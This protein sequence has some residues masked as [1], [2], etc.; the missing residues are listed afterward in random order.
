MEKI[1]DFYFVFHEVVCC[2]TCILESHR[3]C[4]QIA[5]IN[6]ACDGIKSSALVEDVSKAL[7]SLLRT[8]DS[9]IENRKYN[10]ES[11]Y[12]QE[13]TIKESI[14]KLKQCLLQHV[15]SLEK[16]L[17]SDLAKLQ[18]ET[19]SQLDAE[20][21]ESKSLSENWQKTKLEYD[22]NIKHGSNSQFFRL[23]EN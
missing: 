5:L 9:V 1:V 7:S 19:V 2:Q 11:I 6:D 4:E 12:L 3:A 14:V 17:L 16:S 10:K 18:D 22:F 21:S 23:V 8:F 15:D 20:I 13:T